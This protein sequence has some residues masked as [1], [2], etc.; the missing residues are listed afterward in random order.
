MHDSPRYKR[1]RG[2]R[3]GDGQWEGGRKGDEGGKKGR[4]KNSTP[5]LPEEVPPPPPVPLPGL[6]AARGRPCP[7]PP[8]RRGDLTSPGPQLNRPPGYP[9][10]SRGWHPLST[11]KRDR[12]AQLWCFCCCYFV[13]CEEPTQRLLP[14]NEWPRSL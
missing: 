6:H 5:L 1:R 13:F 9:E 10:N 3:H 8:A 14:L 7:L 2:P 12:L 4:S 11:L